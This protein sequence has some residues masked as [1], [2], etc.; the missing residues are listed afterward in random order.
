MGVYYYYVNHSK[1]ELLPID[2]FGGAIKWNGIGRGLGARAF[3]LMM[4]ENGGRWSGDRVAVV[5]DDN[6][7]DWNSIKETYRDVMA[8]AILSIISYDGFEEILDIAARESSVYMQL[9]HMITTRQ[10]PELREMFIER[11]GPSFAKTYSNFC[12]E[13]TWWIPSDVV[14]EKDSE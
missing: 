8:N 14:R 12:K 6:H 1:K 3:A 7:S 5:G 9:S 2:S 10:A 4:V 11:F 13:R